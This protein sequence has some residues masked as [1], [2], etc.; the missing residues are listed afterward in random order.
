MVF[1]ATAHR[2]IPYEKPIRSEM[3]ISLDSGEKI[4][5]L[6]RKTAHIL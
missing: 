3:A 1:D 4:H 6:D 5:F 2:H